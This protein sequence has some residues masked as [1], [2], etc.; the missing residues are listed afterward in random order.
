MC[1]NK[2][3]M[4]QMTHVFILR[5]LNGDKNF[6][7]EYFFAIYASTV[8]YFHKSSPKYSF[9]SCSIHRFHSVIVFFN[10]NLTWNEL[11]PAVNP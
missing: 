10:I 8:S 9:L 2:K 1:K 5:L 11:V 7:S 3:N 6:R 4:I